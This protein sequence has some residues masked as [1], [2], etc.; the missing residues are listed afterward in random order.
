MGGILVFLR[1]DGHV[2]NNRVR[3]EHI[4]VLKTLGKDMAPARGVIILSKDP[5]NAKE[6]DL[7]EYAKVSQ[8]EFEVIESALVKDVLYSYHGIKGWFLKFDKD[9]NSFGYT[10]YYWLL[11]HTSIWKDLPELTI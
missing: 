3:N 6:M 1:E 7:H 11:L 2:E 10:C 4:Q 8:E 5:I 9:R